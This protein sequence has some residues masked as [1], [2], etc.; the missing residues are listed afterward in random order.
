MRRV[1]I[2][3]DLV[4][5][6]PLGNAVD[7][8]DGAAG[9]QE[10]AGRR[11]DQAVRRRRD[12]GR[13]VRELRQGHGRRHHDGV[14][15]AGA[16]VRQLPAADHHPVLAAA[17]DRRRHRGA[18]HHRPADQPA[19]GHRHPD[20]DGHRHQERHHA[21]RLRHRGD[22]AAACRARRPSSMR[23]ASA[24]GPIVMTTIAM[25]GGMLPSAIGD[26]LGRR[27]PRADGDC[28]DRRP[29]V[30]DAAVAGVRAGGVRGD[31]RHRQRRLALLR[32]F[33][34]PTDETEAQVQHAPVVPPQRLPAAA[35]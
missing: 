14:R 4:G 27:V 9:G 19:G 1:L 33:V 17:V 18:G 15:R 10:P 8:R 6:A 29:D 2:G 35:E 31:G 11:R 28:R 32:R 26:G 16:A 3:A 22:A 20:A 13:G 24:R 7:A 25:I 5:N 23:G 21:G 34:G 30:L 12:H